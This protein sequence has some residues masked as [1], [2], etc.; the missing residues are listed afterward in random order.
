MTGG[1]CMKTL[2]RPRRNATTASYYGWTDQAL[3]NLGEPNSECESNGDEE[4]YFWSKLWRWSFWNGKSAVTWHWL[5]SVHNHSD[6]IIA[7]HTLVCIYLLLCKNERL[8]KMYVHMHCSC[9]FD[10]NVS[11]IESKA[12]SVFYHLFT[13]RCMWH[14]TRCFCVHTVCHAF[15]GR[16]PS[17]ILTSLLIWDN[18]VHI[19]MGYGLDSWGSIPGRGKRFVF[20]QRVQT[21]SAAH[22]A[23]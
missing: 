2:Q 20:T 6:F 19:A 18:S 11:K 4:R 13:Q 21:G 5:W 8:K 23:S 22:P 14:V 1:S 9:S 12:I 10:H 16:Q 17:C 15:I 3:N 7:K